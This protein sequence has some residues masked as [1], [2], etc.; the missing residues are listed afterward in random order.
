MSDTTLTAAAPRSASA[1]CGII[2][3]ITGVILAGGSSRRMGENK[4][5]LKIGGLTLI[6]RVYAVMDTLFSD[7]IIITNTPELYCSIPCR[8][9]ADIYP[10]AGSIAGLHAGLHASPSKWIFAAACDMPFLNTEL[11]RLLCRRKNGFDAVVPMNCYGLREPLHA[12]YN[13]S[14]LQVMQQTIEKGDKSIL[15]LLDQLRTRYI[16]HQQ[17]KMIPG[18]E[19]SLRNVNTPEEFAAVRELAPGAPSVCGFA[20]PRKSC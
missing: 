8:T 1:S 18:G 19:E 5:L 9:V 12:L 2:D 20:T 6:E 7:V 11:I 4:A 3:G 17:V 15:I 14:S 16:S 10:G 13:R